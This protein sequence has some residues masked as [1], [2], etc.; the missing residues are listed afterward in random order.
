[1]QIRRVRPEEFER[2]GD[3]L[4]AAYAPS[5]LGPADAYNDTLRDVATRDH[6]AEVWVACE[7]PEILGRVTWCPP[8]SSLREISGPQEAE[9][10]MMGVAPAAQGRGIGRALVEWVIARAA[11]EGRTR[12]V[13]SSAGWMHAAHRLYHSCGFERTPGRDW[14][15][16]PD[17]ALITYARTNTVG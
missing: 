1:M 3:L 6:A 17:I 8:G 11:A 12:L 14:S 2:V 15:P 10:R 4:I 16:R 7:G 5:G 9:F 13:L